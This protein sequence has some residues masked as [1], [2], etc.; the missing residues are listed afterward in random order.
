MPD[1]IQETLLILRNDTDRTALPD[2]ASVRRRGDRRTRNQGIGSAFVLVALVA[3]IAGITASQ[4]GNDRA[5]AP[6]ANPTVSTTQQP[7]LDVATDP[8]LQESDVTGIGP[9]DLLRSPADADAQP[10][11]MQ[12]MPRPTGLGAEQAVGQLFSSDLDGMFT[13]YVL[14]FDT[15]E[16]A[17][18]ASAGLRDTFAGC[19]EGDPAE[20]TVADRE[21]AALSAVT[22]RA[23]RL[24]TPTADAGIGYYELGVARDANIV[25]VLQWSSMGDPTGDA[26]DTW[27]WTA[28][29]LQAALDRATG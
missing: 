18:T 29:R 20:A 7:L 12:C 28:D 10:S 8:F 25:V 17:A 2:S 13:Q 23:S 1:R 27:V 5:D 16:A 21:P 22:F 24:T 4:G 19:P 26:T 11:Q 14:R 3:G 9:Y 6:P 15:A